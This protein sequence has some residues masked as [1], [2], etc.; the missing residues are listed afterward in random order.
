MNAKGLAQRKPFYSLNRKSFSQRKL[1]LD[2]LLSLSDVACSQCSKSTGGSKKNKHERHSTR[3]VRVFGWGPHN[4][5]LQ[6]DRFI[7]R[8]HRFRPRT[9]SWSR[10]DLLV[11]LSVSQLAK[12]KNQ[13]QHEHLHLSVPFV[14]R[15]K[16]TEPAVAEAML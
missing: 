4:G 1:L 5:A 10:F 16:R 12:R 9:M 14:R 2:L 7:P 13:H 6:L 8:I 3:A 15:T 11:F